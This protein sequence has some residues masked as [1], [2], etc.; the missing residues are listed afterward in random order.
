M[1]FQ[2]WRTAA[3][4]PIASH[5]GLFALISSA[6]NRWIGCRPAR[7]I[8]THRAAH[9]HEHGRRVWENGYCESFVGKLREGLLNGEISYSLKESQTVI[10]QFLAERRAKAMVCSWSPDQDHQ[11]WP[12]VLALCLGPL[13]W[14][15]ALWRE[16]MLISGGLI[17]STDFDREPA[18]GPEV[19]DILTRKRKRQHRAPGRLKAPFLQCTIHS[20]PGT[21]IVVERGPPGEIVS[22]TPM[23]LDAR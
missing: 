10:E 7:K 18:N 16:A 4:G 20:S 1:Q 3:S 6:A 8:R 21:P 14:P 13:S 5:Y 9:A 23:N 2:R 12:F 22:T 19:K 17:S 15:L 11:S